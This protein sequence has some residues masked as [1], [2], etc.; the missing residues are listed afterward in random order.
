MSENV[1]FYVNGGECHNGVY[2][3][4]Y[5]RIIAKSGKQTWF[6]RTGY[7]DDEWDKDSIR[8]D[9]SEFTPSK[10]MVDKILNT[11]MKIPAS[12]AAEHT[13][14][15]YYSIDNICK[16]LDV[17]NIGKLKIAY[18]ISNSPDDSHK[19]M[20][21]KTLGG[22]WETANFDEF[23][24]DKHCDTAVIGWFEDE[25]TARKFMQVAIEQDCSSM[26]KII[27]S[28]N[29]KPEDGIISLNTKT[30]ECKIGEAR[31]S[32]PAGAEF[33]SIE[34][35]GLTDNQLAQVSVLINKFKK[36]NSPLYQE[37]HN[38]RTTEFFE[39][40]VWLATRLLKQIK[41]DDKKDCFW[42]PGSLSSVLEEIGFDVDFGKDNITFL[43][44][45]ERNDENR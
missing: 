20:I 22:V 41:E 10:E 25:D 5:A 23:R 9:V 21:M 17:P 15:A 18:G 31:K 6:V 12:Q 2:S 42:T 3:Y 37:V 19:W 38:G 43:N 28:L 40:A 16:F 33:K 24:K 4:W 30:Q 13:F 39:G 45:F 32:L 29:T 34:V 7:R 44:H 36:E 8:F 27:C 26:E 1:E 35:S 11:Y 14:L